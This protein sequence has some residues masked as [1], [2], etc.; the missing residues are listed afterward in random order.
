MFLFV[1]W[2]YSKYG[3]AEWLSIIR[4]TPFLMLI[5]E[6]RNCSTAVYGCIDGDQWMDFEG[7]ELLDLV[8]YD[9]MAVCWWTVLLGPCKDS[10]K[11]EPTMDCHV[12][13]SSFFL[14]HSLVYQYLTLYAAN[15]DQ[16]QLIPSSS[17]KFLFKELQPTQLAISNQALA[18]YLCRLISTSN[19]S[20][21]TSITSFSSQQ[22]GLGGVRKKASKQGSSKSSCMI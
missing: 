21:S 8:W 19:Y 17:K 22:A 2:E 3:T 7:V 15:I 9:D 5:L 12:V 14:F 10:G 6:I 4:S 1:R 11:W 18:I 13:R 16:H 20:I